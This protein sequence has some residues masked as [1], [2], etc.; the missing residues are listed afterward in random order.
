MLNYQRK[1]HKFHDEVEKLQF[2]PSKFTYLVLWF[3]GL[4]EGKKVDKGREKPKEEKLKPSDA[5][6]RK[7]ICEIL[8]EV[9]FNTV[10][11]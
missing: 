7:A 11:I 4:L 9:D 5:A 1:I 3:F 10:S 6:L 2:S 8:K